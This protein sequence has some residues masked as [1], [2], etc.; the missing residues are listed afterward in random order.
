[1]KP[2]IIKEITDAQGNVIKPFEPELVWDITKDP[3]I[4]VLDG[5]NKPTG[6]KIVVEPWVVE[7]VKEGMRLV[8][9]DGTI[10]KEVEFVGLEIPSAGKDGTAEYC[11]NIAQMKNLCQQESWPTHSWYVGYAPFD[12][13]EIAV[14]AFV[15]NGGEGATR[16]GPMVLKTLQAY[17]SLKSIDTAAGTSLIQNP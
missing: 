4:N 6:Q 11:D 8:V 3:L 1:M 13:P 2:T 10:T 16:A 15:Y 12:D 9:V 7:K 17:F 5:N 14:L